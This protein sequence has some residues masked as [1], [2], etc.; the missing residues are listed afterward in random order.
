MWSHKIPPS[1]GFVVGG[2]IPGAADY[3]LPD[4]RTARLSLHS[5]LIMLRQ[6]FYVLVELSVRGCELTFVP[7]QHWSGRGVGDRRRMLWGRMWVA[8]GVL[9]AMQ[10]RRVK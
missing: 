8:P 7:A 4:G 9:A 5:L 6:A 3:A 2:V 10:K 1:Q